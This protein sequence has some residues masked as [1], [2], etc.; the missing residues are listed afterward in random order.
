MART[1]CDPFWPRAAQDRHPRRPPGRAVSGR[2]PR[3]VLG[4]GGDRERRAD[5]PGELGR[6]PRRVAREDEPPAVR[7][8]RPP[9]LGAELRELRHLPLPL[10]RPG[11]VPAVGR[12]EDENPGLAPR[13]EATEPDGERP[14]LALGRDRHQ[15]A[16]AGGDARREVGVEHGGEVGRPPIEAPVAA[17]DR[18]V[19]HGEG[20]GQRR[21]D[22]RLRLGV[23]EEERRHP[24]PARLLLDPQR[25]VEAV[26]GAAG[27]A[28]ED[29]DELDGRQGG[30]RERPLETRI[31]PA[32][33]GAG[34]GRPTLLASSPT[35]G[36]PARRCGRRSS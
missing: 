2:E 19:E 17:E 32:R 25:L 16:V 6:E 5:D 27:Q 11:A 34:N 13:R 31:L 36:C 18:V 20:R 35:F 1:R 33:P 26:A 29:A 3:R 14:R 8:R 15:H 9:E 21:A 7:G 10:G 28:V 23:D 24:P 30:L 22:L 12:E 4:H